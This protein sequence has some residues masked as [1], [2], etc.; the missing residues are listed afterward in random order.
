VLFRSWQIAVEYESDISIIQNLSITGEFKSDTSIEHISISP[1]PFVIIPTRG[2]TLDFSFTVL[3]NTRAIVRIFDLSG[4][5][6]TSLVD[7]YYEASGIL[8]HERDGNAWDGR[9][10]L[11]Q[12]VSPGTYIMHLEVFNPAT[13]ETRTDTAPIVVGVK[14]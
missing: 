9:D 12:I 3:D 1:V 4:R 8:F 7:D 6:I 13:G 10:Q 14:N 11:G 5:F 2:E